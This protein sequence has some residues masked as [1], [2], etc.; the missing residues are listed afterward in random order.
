MGQEA[1]IPWSTHLFSTEKAPESHLP[2]KS[3][4]LYLPLS[5]VWGVPGRH[6]GRECPG[7]GP[8]RRVSGLEPEGGAWSFRSGT[9]TSTARRFLA[10][11]V[12][13][14]WRVRDAAPSRR[15]HSFPGEGPGLERSGLPASLQ[16][17][18]KFPDPGLG[19]HAS[20]PLNVGAGLE[21]LVP[22]DVV[23]GLRVVPAQ[24][25]VVP[26]DAVFVVPVGIL[27]SKLTLA[28]V[29]I[30]NFSH[31]V[32]YF[33]GQKPTSALTISYRRSNLS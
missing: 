27:H 1:T 31:R 22:D 9:V 25:S 33:R 3:T 28:N 13:V 4:N 14:S 6:L 12:P 2:P 24:L 11:G 18:L 8:G 16:L 10:A 5:G 20:L 7:L 23:P 26:P 15:H 21:V 19:G 17:R 29:E 30:P 32:G